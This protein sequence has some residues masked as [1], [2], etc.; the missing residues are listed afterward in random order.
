[1]T[2]DSPPKLIE[3]RGNSHSG[4][5]HPLRFQIKVH[6][7]GGRVP[8]DLIKRHERTTGLWLYVI[9]EWSPGRVHPLGGVPPS[10][11]HRWVVQPDQNDRSLHHCSTL[12]M[13]L[14]DRN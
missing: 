14:I 7:V 13:L 1:M 11:E 10:G 6:P 4:E 3:A 5:T 2:S 9:L 12:W 8:A